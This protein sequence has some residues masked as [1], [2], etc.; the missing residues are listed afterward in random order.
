MARAIPTVYNIKDKD[1]IEYFYF[2]YNHYLGFRKTDEENT[3]GFEWS[4]EEFIVFAKSLY[5]RFIEHP[6]ECALELL[7]MI[8]RFAE[9]YMPDDIECC[10]DAFNEFVFKET[11]LLHSIK[12][13]AK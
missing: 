12:N 5:A 6:E 3:Y 8:K 9:K 10:I 7:D 11:F 13:I 2:L 1:T 4:E